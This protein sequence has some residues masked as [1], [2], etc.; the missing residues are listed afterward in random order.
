MSDPVV[1]VVQN[2]HRWD[3][4]LGQLVPKFDLRPATSFGRLLYLVSPSAKP[5]DPSVLDDM[6]HRLSQYR[7]EDYLLCLGSPILIGWAAA[8]AAD[9]NDGMLTMLQWSGTDR[10]YRPVRAQLWEPDES[11]EEH[12]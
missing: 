12:Y 9:A 3:D 1:Y 8:L 5:W 7:D 6:R 10:E 2:Q 4:R 11:A